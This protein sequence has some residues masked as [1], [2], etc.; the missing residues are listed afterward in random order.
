MVAL[1]SI[2]ANLRPGWQEAG[3]NTKALPKNKS[4]SKTKKLSNSTTTIEKKQ[5]TKI[6]SPTSE[7]DKKC[8]F[9]ILSDQYIGNALRNMG[10][11]AHKLLWGSKEDIGSRGELKDYALINGKLVPAEDLFSTA[12]DVTRKINMTSFYLCT[13]YI[14][15]S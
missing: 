10:H 14:V 9:V 1:Y 4:H 3:S 6:S 13:G 5:E 2:A 11:V 7:E 8:K 15:N 12:E